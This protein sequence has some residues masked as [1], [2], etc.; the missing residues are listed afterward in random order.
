M[1]ISSVIILSTVA[2]IACASHQRGQLYA[3][4]RFV[5]R[6]L[7]DGMKG[8]IPG[9]SK[10]TSLGSKDANVASGASSRPGYD[11]EEFV[12]KRDVSNV[13]NLLKNLPIVDGSGSDVN[14]LL[15]KRDS[16]VGNLLENLPIVGGSG[17]DVNQLLKKRDSGVGSLLENLPI[18]D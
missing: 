18:V 5:Q 17:S 6:G 11:M 7:L 15:K 8:I 2:A 14:Q 3:R 12:V 1:K 10:A 16:G 9:A 13:E 4:N